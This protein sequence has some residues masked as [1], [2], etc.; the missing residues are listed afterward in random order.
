M[1]QVKLVDFP[2]LVGIR[3]RQQRESLLREFAIIASGGGREADVPKRL[4]EIARLHEER[5]AGLN[6]E[7][8]DAIDIAISSGAEFVDL[9]VSV[10]TRVKQDTLDLVPLLLE[11][12]EYCK[13]GDLLTLA[14]DDEIRAYWFWFLREFVRQLNGDS[15]VSW[16]DFSMP[17]TLPTF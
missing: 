10:P 8:D 2:L 13:R 1:R 4:L 5:Y 14:P 9:M 11:V 16:R 15:P 12:D 17:P 3:A 6:P 7:A